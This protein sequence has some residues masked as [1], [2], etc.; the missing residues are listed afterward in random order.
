MSVPNL[1]GTLAGNLNIL[2]IKNAQLF[3]QK[4]FGSN[5]V[6]ALQAQAQ[7][8][9]GITV[10]P[11]VL[12]FPLAAQTV[13]IKNTGANPVLIQWTQVGGSALSVIALQSGSFT[14][15]HGAAA[16]GAGITNITLFTASGASSVDYVL[17]GS[18]VIPSSGCS[19]YARTSG[20]WYVASSASSVSIDG[21]PLYLNVSGSS[22]PGIGQACDTVVITTWSL[23]NNNEA[24]L[25]SSIVDSVGS[26]YIRAAGPYTFFFGQESVEL[27]WAR[28]KSTPPGGVLPITI[29]FTSPS[30]YT[31]L[32][33]ASVWSGIGNLIQVGNYVETASGSVSP[34][35]TT[36]QSAVILGFSSVMKTGSSFPA[37]WYLV[38]G[39]YEGPT[40]TD[41]PQ[42]CNISSSE[43]SVPTASLYSA[44][45]TYSPA[46]AVPS[47]GYPVAAILAAFST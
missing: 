16:T 10:T 23:G 37:G 46:I 35:I 2:N 47:T 9:L 20:G 22:V 7:D 5:A 4:F 31:L 41:V 3:G 6:S 42:I 43:Y 33:S 8:T 12:S 19:G 30:F 18:N 15:V 29:T 28:V 21:G 25:V 45:G 13:Y 17:M 34:T 40:E 38:T 11:T 27:W 1:Q 39:L 26:T 14:L 44:A 24:P 36:S 32:A